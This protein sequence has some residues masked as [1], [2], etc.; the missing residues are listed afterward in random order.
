MIRLLAL[1]TST[2][3][4]GAALLEDD[5]AASV[6]VASAG[7][8]G[9]DVMAARIVPLVEEVLAT[10]GW[11]KSSLD[12]FAAARGPGTFTGLRVGLGLVRG[13][14]I[15]AGRPCV[16]VGTL[17][18]MAEALGPGDRD[19]VPL[20]DAGRREVYAARYDAASH[21]PLEIVPPWVGPLAWIVDMHGGSPAVV[22]GPGAPASAAELPPGWAVERTVLAVAEGV[23][24]LAAARLRAGAVVDE[25]APLYVRPPGAEA[26]RR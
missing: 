11:P 8:E 9:R 21:P 24:R 20:L 2:P 18:A 17:E 26:K 22:F 5:G 15:A 10:A 1:D 6:V 3:R 25:L 4:A 16:G 12:A 23:G 7:F 13:L 14:A 19:R